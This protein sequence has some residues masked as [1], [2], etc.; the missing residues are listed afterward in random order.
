M[1]IIGKDC[2]IRPCVATIG[3]FDGVH[4]GHRFVIRQ[5]VEQARSE[6]LEAVVVTFANHPLQ[7][8]RKSFVPQMLSPEE[9]KV[10]LLKETGIDKIV[11]IEFTRDL[12][13]LSAREFMRSVLKEQIGVKTLLVGYD[14]HF[15]HDCKGYSD[16]VEYGKELDIKVMD[17]APFSPA[18]GCRALS[19]T[20]IRNALLTGDIKTANALLGYSYFLQGSVVRGFQNGRR[21][22]YPTANMQVN[23]LKLIPENGVY[24]VRSDMGFGMLNI[25]TRPTLHNGTERSIEVHLFDFQDDLYDTTMRIE[26]LHHLRKERE[27]GSLEALKR[28]LAEDE[29]ECRA[30]ILSLYI[31]N[32]YD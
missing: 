16:Y 14:N 1:K 29:R 9:E 27:F 6:G 17:I 13:V 19:S 18:E 4:L 3:S 26:I 22:G 10:S 2:S 7:V 21:L 15:G 5:V 30:L 20:A 32:M 11:V 24:L 28:Q 31:Y 25:G 8:L 12:S 23:S